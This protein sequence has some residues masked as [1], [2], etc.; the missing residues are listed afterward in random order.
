MEFCYSNTGGWPTDM[1]W[2]DPTKWAWCKE[3]KT[4]AIELPYRKPDKEVW[5]QFCTEFPS[6]LVATRKLVSG[7]HFS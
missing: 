7:M 6:T 5:F 4:V 3:Q 1:A 2:V